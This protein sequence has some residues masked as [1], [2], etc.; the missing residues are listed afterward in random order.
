MT[1]VLEVEVQNIVKI[2]VCDQISSINDEVSLSKLKMHFLEGLAY[3]QDTLLSHFWDKIYSW[4][5][6][7]RDVDL[8]LSLRV[9]LLIFGFNVFFQGLL[10]VLIGN[11]N[12]F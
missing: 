5:V 4:H 1:L 6:D 11:N 9:H 3:C 2:D 7:F 12:N 8:D 10:G